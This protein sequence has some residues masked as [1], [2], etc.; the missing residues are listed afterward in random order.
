MELKFL[1]T[2]HYMKLPCKFQNSSLLLQKTI[3]SMPFHIN[4]YEPKNEIYLAAKCVN[5]HYVQTRIGQ[6]PDLLETIFNYGLR[7]WDVFDW[8]KNQILLQFALTSF[9]IIF[10]ILNH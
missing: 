10:L 2:N 8:R 9:P 3:T 5:F 1:F 4:S 6:L 7:N